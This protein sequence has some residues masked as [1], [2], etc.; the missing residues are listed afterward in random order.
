MTFGRV[1]AAVNGRFWLF[2]VRHWEPKREER[3]GRVEKEDPR[4]RKWEKKLRKI[5]YVTGSGGSWGGKRP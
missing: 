2:K 4:R 5:R 3:E 1:T